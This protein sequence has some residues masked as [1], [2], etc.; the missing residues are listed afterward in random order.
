M[1]SAGT[2]P[3]PAF[4]TAHPEEWLSIAGAIASTVFAV[5]FIG[6]NPSWE[7]EVNKGFWYAG[8]VWL[9]L[10]YLVVQIAF[11]LFS[12]SQVRAL[13]VLDS[14]LSILPVIAGTVMIVEALLNSDRFH[15]S[16]YMANMLAVVIVTGASEFLL[17]IWIRFV[18]NRRTIGFGGGDG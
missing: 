8:A 11:L 6:L 2:R 1:T 12:A 16:S 3:T 7:P 17:T 4:H 15:L 9:G 18:I 5:V 10:I 13:G 14:V